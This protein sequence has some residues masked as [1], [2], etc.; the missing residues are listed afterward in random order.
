M[1]NLMVLASS[2]DWE[3]FDEEVQA[4]AENANDP[5]EQTR[6]YKVVSAVLNAY[7]GCASLQES[8]DMVRWFQVND[9]DLASR[10]GLSF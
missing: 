3:K 2:S 8:A 6:L 1:K 4:L 10:V 9:S 5:N 7:C